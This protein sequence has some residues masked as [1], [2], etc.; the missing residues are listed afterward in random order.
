MVIGCMLE[1][2]CQTVKEEH[3]RIAEAVEVVLHASVAVLDNHPV[4]L[5][6]ERRG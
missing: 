5:V 4:Q 2:E 6:E 1:M 3:D